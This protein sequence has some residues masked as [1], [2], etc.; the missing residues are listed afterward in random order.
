MLF[1]KNIKSAPSVVKDQIKSWKKMNM[2]PLHPEKFIFYYKSESGRDRAMKEFLIKFPRKHILSIETG[3]IVDIDTHKKKL[4]FVRVKVRVKNGIKLMQEF[5]GNGL[6]F[7]SG[8]KVEKHKKDKTNYNL[9]HK[10]CMKHIKHQLSKL[11]D[12]QLEGFT[13]NMPLRDL[14]IKR[15]KRYTVYPIS[16]IDNWFIDEVVG[17]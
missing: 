5:E 14:L 16:T 8:E 17:P 1:H 15:V 9:E 12:E 11:S 13:K 6:Q 2:E 4:P 10:T 3:M 7:G